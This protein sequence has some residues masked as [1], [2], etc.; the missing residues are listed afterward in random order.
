M[1]K[2]TLRQKLGEECRKLRK[3]AKL[4]QQALAD[5][6][7]KQD[8]GLSFYREDISAFERTGEKLGFE[9]IEAIFDYFNKT[10]EVTEKKTMLTYA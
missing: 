7:N 1:E 5:N 9:K 3:T 8:V 6:L 10:L 4:S 2:K